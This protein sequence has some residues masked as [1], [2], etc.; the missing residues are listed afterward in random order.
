MGLTGVGPFNDL[1]CGMGLFRLM[2][3]R[4]LTRVGPFSDFYGVDW[5]WSAL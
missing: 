2:T 5:G 4:G 3:F 1:W